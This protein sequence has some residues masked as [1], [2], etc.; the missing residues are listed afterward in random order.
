MIVV[1]GSLNMDL[2]TQVKKTPKVGETTLGNGLDKIPGGKGANQAAAMGKLNGKVAMIGRVGEDEF[3]K[4]LKDTLNKDDINTEYIMISKSPTGVAMIMVNEDG[5]NSIVVIPGANFD[6]SKKDIDEAKALIKTANILVAQLETPLEVVEYALKK[7]KK[8]EKYTILNPAPAQ[9]L[10][11]EIIEYVDLLTPNESELELLSGVEIKS[12]EDL[13][14]AGKV[15]IQQG[16][17]ELVVTL[18][19]K[20]ALYMNE[21]DHKYFKGYKVKA[22][23]TTAAG[24]SVNGALAV[25]LDEGR[26]ID[27]AI[28]FAM[29]VG[30]L[31]VMEKG[32][33]SSLPT[34]EKVEKYFK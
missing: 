18:G 28:I 23:D 26:T 8:F 24:D 19:D 33:Q 11:K 29:K 15:M 4:I 22:V 5:D 16:V 3:G 20:G 1:V 21:K 32:A 25:A 34:L 27:E 17:K 7:A 12:E 2:V 14:R 10:S 13:L 30:A 6:L 31:T 9:K